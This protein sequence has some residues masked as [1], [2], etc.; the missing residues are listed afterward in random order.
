[1]PHIDIWHG[2]EQRF[3]HLGNPQRWVNILGTVTPADA[4]ISLNYSLN[5]GKRMPLGMGRD[6]LRLRDAGDFNA[7][8]PVSDL[9][10][11]DNEVVITAAA[12]DSQHTVETVNV[13]YMKGNRWPLPYS[14]DW[15]K[16][17]A[18]GD[19]IQVVDGRWQ[20]TPDGIRPKFPSYDR[21]VTLGDVTWSDYRVTVMVTVHRF[22]K[23]P[24]DYPHF[25]D[26]LAGGFGILSRWTGHYPDG[27]QPCQEWRPSGAHGW[28]RAR[29][30][31]RPVRHRCLNISDGV[32]KD[33][34]VTE[35]PPL[36]LME[37]ERYVFQFS[38][39]S[40]VDATSLYQYKVWPDGQP[41]AL[42][43]N[44]SASGRK[45]ESPRGSV[46]LI[47]LFADI[48]IGNLRVEPL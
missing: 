44:L 46:L 29:W 4:I 17:K 36:A 11:G 33:Q 12:D 16:A 14:I 43:C 18:I 13:Q 19:V 26:G 47:A 40:R 24:A 25:Q 3:G 32:V 20:L 42:L 1:M 30:E 15:Q 2:P 45:G 21:L 28:Y 10:D 27:Y 23:E 48:T 39:K 41:D 8:I 31:D 22:V 9:Q 7:E 37:G 6:A 38:T 34:V 35:T 5:G